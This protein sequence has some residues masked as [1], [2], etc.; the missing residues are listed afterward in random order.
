[1]SFDYSASTQ[2]RSFHSLLKKATENAAE[3]ECDDMVPNASEA[4]VRLQILNSA[5]M[6]RRDQ[7]TAVTRRDLLQ[8]VAEMDGQNR[9]CVKLPMVLLYT[10]VFILFFQVNFHTSGMFLQEVPIRTALSESAAGV[11]TPEGI[12]EW[13]EDTLFPYLWSCS[14]VGRSFPDAADASAKTLVAGVLLRTARGPTITCE[15]GLAAGTAMCTPR[16]PQAP[17]DAAILS[18][19]T[20]AGSGAESRRRLAEL[21]WHALGSVVEAR[22]RVTRRR[23][24]TSIAFGRD[25]AVSRL[26]PRRSGAMAAAVLPGARRLKQ[27]KSAWMEDPVDV[28]EAEHIYTKAVP[29]SA[30]MSDIRG[31]I[32]TFRNSS[33]PLLGPTSL[34]LTA[35]FALRNEE[36]AGGV[37]STVAINF[38]F[39]RGGIIYTSVDI[40]SSLTHTGTDSLVLFIAWSLLLVHLT[41]VQV[42]GIAIAMRRHALAVTMRKFPAIVDLIIVVVGWFIFIGIIMDMVGKMEAEEKW[43]DYV[44]QRAS[45]SDT[46]KLQDFDTEWVCRFFCTPGMLG[47]AARQLL[48]VVPFYTLLLVV[49][50]MISTTGHPRLAIVVNT[51]ALSMTDV[52]HLLFIGVIVF[53]GYVMSGR[54]LFGRRL[55]EFA[56][57]KSSIGNCLQII[58]QRQFDL[59]AITAENMASGTL[60]VVT[61]VLAMVLVAVNIVLAMLFNT[62]GSV[63]ESVDKRDTVV[64][65]AANLARRAHLTAYWLP[66]ADLTMA[67]LKLPPGRPLT[68]V[69]V[70]KALNGAPALQVETVFDMASSHHRKALYRCVSMNSTSTIASLLLSLRH[71]RRGIQ[72]MAYVDSQ[73]GP[74]RRFSGK[75]DH[76]STTAEAADELAEAVVP[77]EFCASTRPLVPSQDSAWLRGTLADH[78]RAQQGRME[79]MLGQLE[80]LKASMSARGVASH[81]DLPMDPPPRPCALEHTVAGTRAQG[82]GLAAGFKTPKA[83]VRT[84]LI[85]PR[86][87]GALPMDAESS[88]T[89]FL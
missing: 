52:V 42:L 62:Y 69:D 51:L 33:D 3:S 43:H 21:V 71:L 74:P 55:E 76:G 17:S 82:A 12:Y 46:S 15:D 57:V 47:W 73:S 6:F 81:S 23:P 31:L 19:W 30:P 64:S 80:E 83:T 59:E 18:T 41:V 50:F 85:G 70:T 39:T 35:E 44:A 14:N 49:R 87:G 8:T 10:A 72:L 68:R 9:S 60:W 13:M 84:C 86:G 2:M 36:T 45:L 58:F 54:I 20:Y 29:L 27:L 4:S 53:F 16:E 37:S 66:Y 65:Y 5:R 79:E 11:E 63:R 77:D 25:G 38:M 32:Q 40:S 89:F 61:L 88:D 7:T 78:L 67:L 24:L 75:F 22:R 26:A 1:M 56:T 34:F 28:S 48:L